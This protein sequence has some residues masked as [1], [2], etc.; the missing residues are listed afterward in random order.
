M[1]GR[2]NVSDLVGMRGSCCGKARVQGALRGS[3]LA[4]T[5]SR[6]GELRM[7]TVAS[8]P[9]WFTWKEWMSQEEEEREEAPWEKLRKVSFSEGWRADDKR[10]TRLQGGV[11][12]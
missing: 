5:C 3:F 6:K 9:C 12:R 10:P 1:R 7:L 4:T 2:A 11:Q 8:T